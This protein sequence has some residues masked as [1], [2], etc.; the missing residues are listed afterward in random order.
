MKINCTFE[1]CRYHGQGDECFAS[2]KVYSECEFI[3]LKKSRLD[4]L[5]K[6]RGGI[7]M[8]CVNYI[9]YTFY[10]EQATD[11]GRKVKVCYYFDSSKVHYGTII[12][13]DV[14]EPY[15]T[16]IKLD[17]GRVLLASECQYC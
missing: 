5:L 2:N 17:N 8:G 1:K 7:G 9:N 16:I 12:R 13:S 10:P 6:N 15:L 3:F 11:L 4:G 14:S